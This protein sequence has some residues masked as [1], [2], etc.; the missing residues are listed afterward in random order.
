MTLTAESHALL[1]EN[2]SFGSSPP[3]SKQVLMKTSLASD[4]SYLTLFNEIAV[5]TELIAHGLREQVYQVLS[6]LESIRS[7]YSLGYYD[8]LVI[9][10]RNIVV[11]QIQYPLN[12]GRSVYFNLV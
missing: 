6:E 3:D 7:I 5:N 9:G 11:L 10:Y 1:M 12:V 8:H 4:A 2:L